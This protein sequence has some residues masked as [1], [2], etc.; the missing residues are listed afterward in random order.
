Q[1]KFHPWEGGEGK[2]SGQYVY[3]KI[4][5]A[6]KALRAGDATA[7]IDHLHAAQ[8]YP[9]SLGEGKLHGAQ[10]NDIFFWLGCAL[11]QLGN[12]DAIHAF[13]QATIGPDKPAPAMFY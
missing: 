12:P 2:A 3:S 11:T 6:K 7:A 5:L 4:A 13:Q 1:R 10:E 8:A 9:Q